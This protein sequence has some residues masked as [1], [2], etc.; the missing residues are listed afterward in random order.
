LLPPWTP[1][2]LTDTF[3]RGIHVDPRQIFVAWAAALVLDVDDV[4][5]PPR[6]LGPRPSQCHDGGP[7]DIR[8]TLAA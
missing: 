6:G 7:R 4:V 8:V 3:S 2:P 5:E 1:R